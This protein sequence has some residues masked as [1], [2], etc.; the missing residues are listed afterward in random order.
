MKIIIL[1][2]ISSTCFAQIPDDKKL[3]FVAGSF[4]A[5]WAAP[6]GAAAFNHPKGALYVGPA[7][8]FLGGTIK[9]LND[10]KQPGNRFDPKDLG[11]TILGGV[12]FSFVIY[13]GWKHITRKKRATKRLPSN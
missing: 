3:H 5:V 2:L 9:E 8:A 13:L 11:A 6:V 12:S 4:L 7:F 1:L 10:S